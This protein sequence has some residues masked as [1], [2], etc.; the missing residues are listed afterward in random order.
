[1]FDESLRSAETI[2][3]PM[4]D[5]ADIPRAA[6]QLNCPLVE[7][8]EMICDTR[9]P[10]VGRHVQR[11]GFAAIFAIWRAEQ[12]AKTRSQPNSS[13]CRKAFQGAKCSAS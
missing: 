7:V 6:R 8:I 2:Y 11:Y 4:H 10:R 1:M 9:L 3:V 13:Q 5:W 12:V